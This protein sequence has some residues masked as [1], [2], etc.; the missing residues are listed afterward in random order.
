MVRARRPAPSVAPAV[1][2]PGV[3]PW[4]AAPSCAVTG[5]K[6]PRAGSIPT[7]HAL[8]TELCAPHRALARNTLRKSRATHETLLAYLDEAEARAAVR[9]AASRDGT[10]VRE[11]VLL[12]LVSLG[13]RPVTLSTLVVRAWEREPSR[14]GLTGHADRYPD[15]NRVLAK[16]SGDDGI[17]VQGWCERTAI[18]VLV[19]TAKGRRHAATLATGGAR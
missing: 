16:L 17:V 12:A 8:L 6:A 9:S 15:S 19:L 5:C 14:F 3:S 13:D 7:T 2:H 11:A 10:S 18:G 4:V 1:G